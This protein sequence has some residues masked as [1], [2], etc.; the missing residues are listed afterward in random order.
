MTNRT[1]IALMAAALTLAMSGQP[2]GQTADGE[3]SAV[4]SACPCGDPADI[5]P[6]RDWHMREVQ[7]TAPPTSGPHTFSLR[8]LDMSVPV[9]QASPDLCF[10]AGH[11]PAVQNSGLKVSQA[12]ACGRLLIS[13]AQTLKDAGT[14]VPDDRGCNLQ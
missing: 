10:W 8:A 4:E 3:P 7:C 13:Y 12:E 11:R 2:R 1:T 14:P 6:F 9:L 5:V